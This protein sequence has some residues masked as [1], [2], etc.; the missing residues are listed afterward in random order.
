MEIDTLI[1]DI[2]KDFSEFKEEQITKLDK[3]ADRVDELEA[4]L[5]TP[6]TTAQKAHTTGMRWKME[7]GREITC[8]AKGDRLTAPSTDPVLGRLIKSIITG[9]DDPDLDTKA[10]VT[11][12]DSTGGYLLTTPASRGA[13]DLARAKSVVT[14]AGAQTVVLP[15]G[16]NQGRMAKLLTDPDVQFTPEGG[17][18][19]ESEMTFG[20]Q[21]IR[22]RKITCLV[23]ASRELIEYGDNAAQLI[24]QTLQNALGAEMD[25][26]ALLGDGAGEEPTGLA[27]MDGIGSI[28][29]VGD[30]NYDDILN[31][32]KTVRNAFHEPTGA[33]WSPGTDY[34]LAILKDSNDGQYLNPPRGYDALPKYTTT[35]A[36]DALA[37]V[38]DF[39]KLFYAVSPTGVRLDT[40]F[41]G[42]GVFNK[43]MVQFRVILPMDVFA[44]HEAAFCQLSGL[45]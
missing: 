10:H 16:Y 13:I 40:S 18:I 32:V 22:L 25:R 7:D 28:T 21:S 9:K 14:A 45:S 42:D 15:D 12:Q 30:V 8:L 33:I 31:A 3:T 1:E 24:Q 27:N 34:E 17:T 36:T 43:D 41:H 20:I 4:K 44:T 19:P 11:G 39:S 6:T 26:V 29:G 37:F 35:K 23:S 38:G 2:G 5:N